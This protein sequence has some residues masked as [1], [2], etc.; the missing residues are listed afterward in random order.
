MPLSSCRAS[1]SQRSALLLR[2]GASAAKSL[3]KWRI[4]RGGHGSPADLRD[5]IGGNAGFAICV[6]DASGAS[7]PLLAGAVV[8]GGTCG[9][10]PCWKPI[11]GGYRYKNKA[12]T[13]DGVTDLKLRL[14]AGG[15][16]QL[17]VKGK[18][19]ALPLPALGLTTPVDVQLVIGDGSGTTCWQS[20]F[21]IAQKNE[22]TLFKA[23]GS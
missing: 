12:A 8:A 9:P 16:L 20:S 13:S 15:E 17:L 4:A 6:Y 18:G 3:L 5:P 10:K 1:A 7:Q 14:S 23:N 11:A 2:A 21:P 22:P 19:A